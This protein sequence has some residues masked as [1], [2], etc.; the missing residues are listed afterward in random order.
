MPMFFGDTSVKS[1]TKKTWWTS[2]LIESLSS[3][4]SSCCKQMVRIKRNLEFKNDQSGLLTIQLCLLFQFYPTWRLVRRG[5]DSFIPIH[6]W[7]STL[8][9]EMH[10][11]IW[12]TAVEKRDQAYR[13]SRKKIPRGHQKSFRLRTRRIMSGR[14]SEHTASRR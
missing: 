2:I 9:V 5:R 1:G 6:V 13:Q 11:E 4:I 7:T 8:L 10:R 3:L 14:D 12:L